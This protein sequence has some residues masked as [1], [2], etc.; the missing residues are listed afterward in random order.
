MVARGQG[1]TKLCTGKTG[2][3]GQDDVAGRGQESNGIVY[4]EDRKERPRRCGRTRTGITELCTGKTGKR[5]Q[6]DVAGR[7]QE[8]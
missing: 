8:V 2:K 6:D 3:K 4:R 5:G 1:V 7:G